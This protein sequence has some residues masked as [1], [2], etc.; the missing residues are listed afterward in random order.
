MLSRHINLAQTDAALY[1][2]AYIVFSFNQSC[3][4][5]LICTKIICK[6]IYRCII[7][8][9]HNTSDG[10]SILILTRAVNYLLKVNVT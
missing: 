4:V 1:H 5:K 9:L 3:Y 6:R 10:T 8:H 2:V 7:T